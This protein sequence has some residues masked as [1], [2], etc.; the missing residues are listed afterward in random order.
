MLNKSLLC[1][2]LVGTLG[3]LGYG[4][5]SPAHAQGL[6]PDD[7]GFEIETADDSSSS[8]GLLENL[9]Q[10]VGATMGAN[11]GTSDAAEKTIQAMNFAFDLPRFANIKSAL[12]VDV[13]NYENIYKLE[14]N[15]GAKQQLSQC[16]EPARTYFHRS[17]GVFQPIVR[18]YSRYA[19]HLYR[20]DLLLNF[21][22]PD[23]RV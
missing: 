9:S 22:R 5:M 1:A 4:A 12:S 19:I 11:S 8:G 20:F 13:G 18:L 2:A 6:P 3:S 15:E 14:I 17:F 10:Y 23:A 16:Q 21:H 7:G